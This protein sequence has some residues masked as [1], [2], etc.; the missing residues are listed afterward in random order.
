MAQSR[1]IRSDKIKWKLQEK[2]FVDKRVVNFTL[3]LRGDSMWPFLRN[4]LSVKFGKHYHG[5]HILVG[6]VVAI[7]T[8]NDILVHRIVW[9]KRINKELLY[10][11]KGDCRLAMDGW[12]TE[13]RIYGILP[14]AKWKM[15]VNWGIVGY[16]LCLF[17][18]GKV[19]KRS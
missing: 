4:G 2:V 12:I 3:T 7:K 8:L 18:I 11:T 5:H 15:L 10:L 9:K 1:A 13:E 17:V 14:V 6:S 19:L 16:S